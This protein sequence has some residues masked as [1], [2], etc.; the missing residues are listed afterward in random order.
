M[1]NKTVI[2]FPRANRFFQVSDDIFMNAYLNLFRYVKARI[3]EN[4]L[5]IIAG[6]EL[7][8]IRNGMFVGERV[9]FEKSIGYVMGI[10][11]EEFSHDYDRDFM[12]TVLKNLKI[13]IA[14]PI[15]KVKKMPSRA[16]KEEGLPVLCCGYNHAKNL[17]VIINPYDGQYREIGLDDIFMEG[18][19]KRMFMLNVPGMLKMEMLNMGD[20]VNRA[21]GMYFVRFYDFRPPVLGQYCGYDALEWACNHRLTMREVLEYERHVAYQ[22]GW[23]N[24]LREQWSLLDDGNRR[25]VEE[26]GRIYENLMEKIR[27]A[28][29]A[30]GAK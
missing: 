3:S 9:G 19:Q 28:K 12:E 23:L 13:R 8:F 16:L 26:V 18:G 2:Y 6:G 1:T 25:N 10:Y 21:V 20:M 4:R 15:L 30:G 27:L 11:Y 17:L 29:A 5:K 7:A 24:G 14:V 22:T